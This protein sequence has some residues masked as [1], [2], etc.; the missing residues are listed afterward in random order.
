[1]SRAQITDPFQAYR[2]HVSA[3]KAGSLE[4]FGA[5]TAG[6]NSVTLPTQTVESVEYKEGIMV[7]RRKYPGD[8]TFDDVTF[9]RG[10]TVANSEF[11]NWMNAVSSGRAY[12]V[13][14]QIKQFHRVDITDKADFSALTPSRVIK[15]YECFPVSVKPGSDMD[16]M[17]SD[18]SIQEITLS[19]EKFDI[20]NTRS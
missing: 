2:F 16:S 12:R 20:T 11:W 14:L 3:T 19:L 9:T 10:V 7:Y 5:A 13:D 18:I 17:T 1:M 15:C 8:T 6:F 4:P